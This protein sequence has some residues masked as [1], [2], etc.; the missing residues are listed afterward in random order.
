M[1]FFLSEPRQNAFFSQINPRLVRFARLM[2]VSF[3][4]KGIL[5]AVVSHDPREFS[6]KKYLPRIDASLLT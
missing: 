6:R 3:C 4:Q 5:E 2:K 1:F